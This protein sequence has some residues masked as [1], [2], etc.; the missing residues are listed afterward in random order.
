MPPILSVF[1]ALVDCKV[2]SLSRL[3]DTSFFMPI[4]IRGVACSSDVLFAGEALVA[5]GGEVEFELASFF[6]FGFVFAFK[7]KFGS[8]FIFEVKFV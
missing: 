3:K 8:T 1:A 5:V 7:F 6:N 2:T 4:D